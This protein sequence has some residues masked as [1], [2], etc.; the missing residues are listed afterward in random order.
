MHYA[1]GVPNVGIFADMSLLVELAGRTEE[2]GWDGWFLWDHI[3][4]HDPTWPVADPVVALSAAAAVTDRIRLG[5]LMMA[6]PRHDPAIVAKQLVAVDHLSS[7][8]LTTGFGLG[9]MD[10]EYYRFG[11]DP[12]LRTRADRLDEGL[13]LMSRS[14]TG[15]T[16][17]FS[18]SHYQ[19]E[20][21]QMRP[22]PRQHPRPPVWVAGRWPNR[23]PFLRA[24]QWD[25]VMP[26]QADLAKGETMSAQTVATIRDYLLAHRAAGSGLDIAIEG[27]TAPTVRSGRLAAYARAGVTWWIEA[28]G[29]WRGDAHTAMAR[30]SAGPPA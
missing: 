15:E 26:T 3:L 19:V 12:D 8:R 29:W 1:I 21:V 14:W 18:G 30:V 10:E 7:G 6:L 4:Y 22:R 28:L 24:A 13:E 27:T 11:A 23:R 20:D 5:I 9:S 17:S 16:F 25:G 2:A